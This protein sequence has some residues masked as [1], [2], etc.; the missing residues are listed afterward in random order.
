[1]RICLMF[2]VGCDGRFPTHHT[3]VSRRI[4]KGT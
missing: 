2:T 3:F 4:M 1:V